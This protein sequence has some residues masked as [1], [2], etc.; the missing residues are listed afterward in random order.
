[1]L[2]DINNRS[3]LNSMK[4]G[5]SWQKSNVKNRPDTGMRKRDNQMAYIWHTCKINV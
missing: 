5:I 3:Q 4:S 2:S 1:M